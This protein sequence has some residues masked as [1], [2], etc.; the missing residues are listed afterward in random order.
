M[1]ELKDVKVRLDLRYDVRDVEWDL[2]WGSTAQGGRAD[3]VS[4]S[5]GDGKIYQAVVS[6]VRIR[7]DGSDGA[8]IRQVVFLSNRPTW[9]PPILEDAQRQW[10][11]M[12][13]RRS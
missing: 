3:Y 9:L 6:G 13:L 11:A 10:D 8:H 7:K 12:L 1:F 5:M 2:E 4:V